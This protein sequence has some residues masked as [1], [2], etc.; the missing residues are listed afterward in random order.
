MTDS[1]DSVPCSV[2]AEA[3]VLSLCL[4]MGKD[5]VT[6]VSTIL[7]VDDFYS[8]AHATIY[9]SILECHRRGLSPDVLVVAQ[10]LKDRGLIDKAGGMAY[11]TTVINA[12]PGTAN[13]ATYADIVAKKAHLRRLI[14][15]CREISTKAQSEH[16]DDDRFIADSGARIR[17]ICKVSD[18]TGMTSSTDALK[19]VFLKIQNSNAR[20]ATITGLPT[21]ISGIDVL[22]KGL[23]NKGLTVVAGRPGGGKSALLL[24]IAKTTI[25]DGGGVLF[26][27]LEMTRDAMM[28]RL[29]AQVSRVDAS[30]L[31]TGALSKDQW[32]AVTAA[33]GKLAALPFKIDETP[34]LTAHQIR[35]RVLTGIQD[36]F[37]EKKPIKLIAVDYV[38]RIRID[39]A[40]KRANR[41]EQVGKS[42][43]S[44]KELA[45]E[46][47]LPVVSAAQLRRP[48]EGKSG[49]RPDLS[50]L[51]ESGDIEQE[52]DQLIAIWRDKDQAELILLKNRAGLDGT[53][54]VKWDAPLTQFSDL[55]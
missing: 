11:I 50:S 5:M 53:V 22:T 29:I 23:H 2:D 12:A 34:D 4:T 9:S 37:M 15:A 3:A 8:S 18:K 27:S 43:K 7:R 36:G 14:T 46:V 31:E 30:L 1:A 55:E 21:G 41:Y 40:D 39:E 25:M 24:N 45:K 54:R 38:Q 44:L 17:D 26:F 32:A 13:V 16:G 33:V 6:R 10:N 49:I 48:A 52:C 51:R 35:Q 20:G 28:Q 19:S 47:D 42:I